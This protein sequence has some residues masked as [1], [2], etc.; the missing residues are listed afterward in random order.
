MRRFRDWPI[1]QKLLAIV[2]ATTAAALLMAGAGILLLDTVL[3]RQGMQRDLIALARIVAENTTGALSFE[4]PRAATETLTALRARQH[5]VSACL[6]RPGGD[7]FA[8]YIRPGAQ[9]SCPP[10]LTGDGVRFES[11]HV[12]VWR[13]VVLAGAPIGSLTLR[14]DLDEIPERLRLYGLTVA[15]ILLAAM[16][17]A[18]VLM[19]RL[20]AV[21][22]APISRLAAAAS[23]VSGTKD[24][25]IRAERLSGDE[26]GVLVDA[27]NEMLSG[28][29]S[30]D[31]E[32][33]AAVREAQT[34]RNSLQT[35]LL[36]IGDAVISTDIEG[37]IVFANPVAQ[38]LLRRPEQ[39][40]VGR[41]VDEVFRIVNEFSRAPVESPVSKVLREGGIVGLANHTILLAGD[42]T[43]IPIDDS[44]APIQSGGRAVGVVLV[45]RDVTARRRAERDAA[46]L[47]ALVESSSDAVVGYSPEGIIQSWNA[48]AERLYG[49][50]ADEILGRPIGDLAPPDRAAE[51]VEFVD[52]LR[53]GE[54]IVHTETLRRRKDGST[55][56]VSLAISPI[57]NSAGQM[58]GIS[59]VA[60]DITEQ[61]LQTEKLRQTQKL[62]SIGILAGGI[63]HDFNNLLAGILGNAS[64]ALEDV[65][66]ASDVRQRLIDVIA[67]SEKAAELT[68]Q[69]LAYSGKGQFV[70]ERID[71]SARIRE[72]MRLIQTALHANVALEL[73]LQAGLPAIEADPSQIQQLVMNI[74]I[75]AAEAIPAGRR[76]TVTVSTRRLVLD[77]TQI[78]H[79]GP[80]AG[81]LTPGLHV[82]FEV[83]D[84]GVG[85]DEATRAKIFDPFFTTKFTGRGLGL[86]AVLGIVRGHH[87]FIGVTSTP[88]QGATFRVLLPAVEAAVEPR[89]QLEPARRPALECGGK[90]LVVDDEEVVRRMARQILEHYRCG[91]LLAEDGARGVEIFTREAD[92]IGCV[93]LDLTMPVMSGEEAL[94]RM[95]S[96]RTD[97]PIVISSG[98][99]KAEA[100]RRFDGKGVAGFLQKPYRAVAFMEAVRAATAQR[101][102]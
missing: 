54:S 41:P 49:Y 16:A 88:G 97:I 99:N 13:P 31:E 98:Y 1:K 69:M 50:R 35:T 84:N 10:L 32:L 17:V 79:L 9:V 4:D 28:I 61:K 68:R 22:A 86:A 3:F 91:V 12:T 78:R 21:I 53:A 81:E 71:L 92:E 62:E 47:A 56:D 76:G 40:I 63:A 25:R 52:R 46:Y 48:G 42:G 77:G 34:A 51:V 2:M 45:F 101:G 8:S 27:F 39:E 7:V 96:L 73:D 60:R 90:V 36:S 82:L 85:M 18:F 58:I 95:R 15:V 43:E 6:F 20:R 89:A 55:V 87:G 5:L 38:S 67:A 75:N 102:S 70:L 94:Q 11:A 44:G 26:L 23:S 83:A 74:I 59:H 65:A 80:G 37:R 14:F 19:S 33:K 24:Y 29:Q 64:L 72:T 57:R 30:R 66:P 93:I 100:M